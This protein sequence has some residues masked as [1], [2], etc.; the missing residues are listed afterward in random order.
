MNGLPLLARGAVALTAVLAGAAAVPAHGAAQY[1][2]SPEP[3]AYALQDA[4]VIHGDGSVSEGVTLVVRNGVVETLEAGAE[5][6]PDAEILEGEDLHVHPGFVD[7][8]GQASMALPEVDREGVQAWNPTREVQRF[9][10]HRT[11]RE[12]LDAT[13]SDLETQRENGVVASVAFPGQ[14]IM[15]GQGALLVHRLQADRPRELVVASPL[16]LSMAFQGVPGTYPGTLFGVKALL[17]QAF[18]DAD[19]RAASESAFEADPG[20]LAAPAR[21]ADFEVLHRVADGELPVFARADGAEDIR[22]VLS[23]SDELG[24]D[25]VIV[26]GEEA[27]RVADELAARDVPV[28]VSVDFPEPNDW[29]PDADNGE[30][31]PSAERERRELEDIYSNPARLAEAGV[32]FSFT[33]AGRAA[34][35]FRDGVLKALEYGLSEEDALRALS[36]EPAELLGVPHLA[37]VHEGSGAT[38]VVTDG[39]AFQEDSRI[40]YTFVEGGL[41]RVAPPGEGLEDTDEPPADLDGTWEVELIVGGQPMDATLNVEQDGASFSGTLESD[42]GD[43][44]IRNGQIAGNSFRMEIQPAGAPAAFTLDLQGEVDGD[45][46]TASGQGPQGMG[47]IEIRGTREPGSARILFQSEEGGNR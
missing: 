29:D 20:G 34:T 27:W 31:D 5:P 1:E 38:F 46:L 13:G 32:R 30:L 40:A 35:D 12:Y 41:E 16:G 3:A 10:P 45:E 26:G 17:R 2:R 8:Y 47:D 44:G 15:P 9:T 11:A 42:M 24:F 19:H 22:R 28:A 36:A 33:S 25:P 23:L 21:D 4:T 7:P 14:G 39:P 43:S 18:L 37:Q 6:P